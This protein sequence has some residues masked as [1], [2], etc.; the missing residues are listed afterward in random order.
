MFN[1]L[2]NTQLIFNT[3]TPN[4]FATLQPYDQDLE[5]KA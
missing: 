1:L 2:H 4:N 3:P 5:V